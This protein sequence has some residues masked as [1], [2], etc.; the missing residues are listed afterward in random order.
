MFKNRSKSNRFKEE[1]V[2]SSQ[3]HTDLD[4]LF[5]AIRDKKEDH[6]SAQQKLDKVIDQ[7]QACN[8][9]DAVTL[10][11]EAMIYDELDMHEVAYLKYQELFK[12]DNGDYSIKALEQYCLVLSHRLGT[13]LRPEQNMTKKQT[14]SSYL[15]EIKLLTLAGKNPCRLNI[16]GNAFKLSTL[17][18]NTKDKIDKFKTAYNTYQ[19]ALIISKNKHDGQYLEAHSNLIQIG[20]FL[21]QLGDEKPLLN[22]LQENPAFEKVINLEK[23]LNDFYEEL[24]DY[25]KSDLDISVLIGMTKISY[26][27]MLINPESVN[28][29]ELNILKWYRQIFN[30]IYSPRYVKI[31]ILQ[32][33]FFLEN[34]KDSKIKKSLNYIKSELQKY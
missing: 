30:Q 6:A 16:I 23:Y 13:E 4:N 27:L 10:E 25:D 28:K 18:F 11:K 22:R 9:L 21:E 12:F 32:I 24:D 20:Y 5:I 1:Y 29:Q 7:A 31:E 15:N 33:E 8:L 3:V 17:H 2:V 26:A 34:L 14:I 19:E